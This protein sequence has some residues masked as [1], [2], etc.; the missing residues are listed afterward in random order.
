MH[1]QLQKMIINMSDV[2]EN[3][4]CTFKNRWIN[5]ENHCKV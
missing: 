1:V 3:V 5:F 4:T 2:G